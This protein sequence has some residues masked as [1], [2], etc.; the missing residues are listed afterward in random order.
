MAD[1]TDDD[2]PRRPAEELRRIARYQR[3]V[4][5]V[6]LAEVALWVGFIAISWLRDSPFN[7][8]LRIPIVFSFILGGVGGIFTF[9]LYWTV[10]GPLAAMLHGLTAVPP[11]L[12]TLVLLLA[13]TTATTVLKNHGVRVGIFGA[14]E[15]DIPDDPPDDEFDGDW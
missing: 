1:L 15:A 11:A 4:V 12:G 13:N 3:W 14:F 2:V 6:I 7:D 8:G 9:L 10:R 5:A